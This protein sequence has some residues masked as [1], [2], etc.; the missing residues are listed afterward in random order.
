MQKP[1]LSP[2]KSINSKIS[3]YNTHNHLLT[4]QDVKH[5]H[6]GI[7]GHTHTDRHIHTL[8][9][10]VKYSQINSKD[11]HTPIMYVQMK[12]KLRVVLI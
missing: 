7:E 9:R 11:M 5:T 1:D 4:R 2:M 12:G 3:R 8:T 6:A 10:N